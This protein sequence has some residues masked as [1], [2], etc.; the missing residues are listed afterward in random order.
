M[1]VLLTGASGLLGRAVLREL[2]AEPAWQVCGTAFS[3][4]RPGLVRLDLCDE[5]AVAAFLDRTRPDAIVH[6]AAERRPDVSER[7]PDATRRL[8]VAATG[9]LAEWAAR[10]GAWLVYLSTDYVFDGTMP[11]YRPDAPT[12]PLNR[13][14]TSKRDGERTVWSASADA[15][16][17][18]VPILYGEVES[19]SES[20]VTGVAQQ[21]LDAR[22]R[23]LTIEAWATRY[24]THC[25]DVA[26]V[27]R[28]MLAHRLNH[29]DFRGTFHWS[30]SEALTKYDMAVVMAPLLG[31]D[32]STVQPDARAPA[33]AP[34]PK[35][36][37]LDCRDLER[38]GMGRRTPFAAAMRS[39]LP[40]F[41]PQKGT[42]P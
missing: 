29:R 27:I 39:L 28:Q 1:T 3:R 26:C 16:V 19:L 9:R 18:R 31:I 40:R 17:L 23:A 2:T 14:G 33:G 10:H 37:H 13:Y 30:G 7:D 41:A 25:D 6:A 11:P 21:L 5:P 15:A 12:H 32:P 4:A 42:P 35:D 34:R 22:G 24:P 38:L 20:A 8:N 36:C